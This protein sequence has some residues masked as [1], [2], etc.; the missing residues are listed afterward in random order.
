MY[1]KRVLIGT[2]L[3][4]ILG[5]FRPVDVWAVTASVNNLTETKKEFYKLC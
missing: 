3:G 2:A 5:T 1:F 4:C